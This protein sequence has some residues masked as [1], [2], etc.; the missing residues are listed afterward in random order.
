ML[1]NLFLVYCFTTLILCIFAICG[2]LEYLIIK[3]KDYVEK[4]KYKDCKITYNFYTI[5]EYFEK[6]QKEKKNGNI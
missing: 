5:E 4:Q 6:L 1:F 3:L 2:L